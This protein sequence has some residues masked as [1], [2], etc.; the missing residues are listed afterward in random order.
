VKGD[1]KTDQHSACNLL[2]VRRENRENVWIGAE[3]GSE[4]LCLAA[5]APQ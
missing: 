4:F 1:E 2:N 3:D 5:P